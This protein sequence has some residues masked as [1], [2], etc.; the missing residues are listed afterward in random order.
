MNVELLTG[1]GDGLS[2][3]QIAVQGPQQ[4]VAAVGPVHLLQQAQGRVAEQGKIPDLRQAVDDVQ[5]AHRVVGVETAVRT[6]SL[7]QAERGFCLGEMIPQSAFLLEGAADSH[8]QPVG[9]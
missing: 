5:H 9:L 6:K 4:R 7:P 8:A 3:L 2:V 1:S